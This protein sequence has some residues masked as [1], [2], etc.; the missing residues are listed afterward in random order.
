MGRLAEFKDYKTGYNI[1]SK[2]NLHFYAN[3]SDLWTS[4]QFDPL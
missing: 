3:N 4:V 2:F 1:F